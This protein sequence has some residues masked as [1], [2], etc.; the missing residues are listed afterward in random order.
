[1]SYDTR[2]G[3]RSVNNSPNEADSEPAAQPRLFSSSV[4]QTP[5]PKGK[6]VWIIALPV[7]ALLIAVAAVQTAP[8]IHQ[9][10]PPLQTFAKQRST[11]PALPPKTTRQ[12]A[13]ATEPDI[14]VN[15]TPGGV[16]SFQIDVRGRCRLSSLETNEE[17]ASET[18]QTGIAPVRHKTD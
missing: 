6:G 5:S 4:E 2:A 17:L 7:L 18:T 13:K 3:D 9:A 15:V 16:Q 12:R 14:R 1:M 10:P 11:P 8:V